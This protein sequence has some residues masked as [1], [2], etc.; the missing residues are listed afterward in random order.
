[1][2]LLPEAS[3]RW[4]VP[5][6]RLKT[7]K[8]NPPILHTHYSGSHCQH[9][10][11]DTTRQAQKS[12]V[13][14]LEASDD[15]LDETLGVDLAIV[16]ADDDDSDVDMTFGS[17]KTAHAI[18]KRKALKKAKE[19]AIPKKIEK[20]FPF[21][22][23]PAEFRDYIYEL[24]LT[25][26]NGLTLI[27]KTKKYR[28][29]AGPGAIVERDNRGWFH[30][31]RRCRHRRLEATPRAVLSPA[32]LAVSKQIHADGVNYLYHQPI[33]VEDTYALHNFVAAI[34]SNRARVTDL[35]I[36]G[37]GDSRGARKTMNFCRF[38]L[39]AGC[40]N[41]KKLYLDCT[42]GWRRHPEGLA[43]QL[44][45]DGVYFFEAYGAANGSKGAAVEILELSDENHGKVH[46]WGGADTSSSEAEKEA[47]KDVHE[48]RCQAELKKLLG[49]A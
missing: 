13:I 41:L 8:H 36:K 43:R 30:S 22:K 48:E 44:Y 45:R 49:C 16:H 34:G 28:R 27:S 6:T 47:E 23:L 7:Y 2:R 20:P 32:L 35:T 10:G 5:T 46:R 33:V 37:W 4:Q 40:T 17:H 19:P 26:E 39:L 24:A 29:T 18:K 25:D 11:H 42:I 3:L 12:S 9:V 38:T 21:E 31:R 14:Y 1:M 15:E